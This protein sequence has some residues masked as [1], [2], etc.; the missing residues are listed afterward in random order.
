VNARLLT[1]ALCIL[2]ALALKMHAPQEP[3]TRQA[4]GSACDAPKLWT[5]PKP[6]TECY[7]PPVLCPDD[8]AA[9]DMTPHLWTNTTP[10]KVVHHL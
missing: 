8:D 2:L 4:Q 5:N 1:L 7:Q 6:D 9:C 3:A 10:S